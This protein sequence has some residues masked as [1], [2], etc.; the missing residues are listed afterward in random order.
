[1]LLHLLDRF[2]SPLAVRPKEA[3]DGFHTIGDV[4]PLTASAHVVAC[5]GRGLRHY[6]F[7]SYTRKFGFERGSASPVTNLTVRHGYQ[8]NIGRRSSTGEL[9]VCGGEA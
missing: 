1:M 9:F 4:V 5:F 8:Q 3:S 7:N 6:T 2:A